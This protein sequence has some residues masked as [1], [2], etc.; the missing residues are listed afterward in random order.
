MMMRVIEP[1]SLSWGRQARDLIAAGVALPFGDGGA[2]AVARLIEVDESS[3]LVAAGDLPADW[4][5]E[6]ARLA[7]G[8]P[9]AGLP[10]EPLVMGILNVTPDSFSDGGSDRGVA[11]SVARAEAMAA[12]GA[13]IIDVGGES[14]RPRAAFVAEQEE[15]DRVV[16]VIEGLRGIAAKISI[17]TRRAAVMRAALAAGAD[18]INDVSGLSF[19]PAAGR[20]A[21]ETGAP[22]VLMHMRGDPMTMDRHTD[23]ADVAGEVTRE[24]TT[25]VAAALAAGVRR[26]AIMLDPGVGFAKTDA[27]SAELLNRL[28]MLANLGCPLL[29]GASR[30]RFIGKF[31]GV[32]AARDRQAGSVAAALAGIQR[33]ARIVRVHD[34]AAT[35]QAIRVWRALGRDT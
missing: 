14:T 8:R 31:S 27:Q 11:D 7:G 29:L 24:L 6:A 22:V 3:R 34:V 10:A 30:K 20:V 19:D 9:W 25:A 21:A 17:D 16:P 32:D 18:I 1:L 35:A 2:F 15:L 28:A 33:G 5:W 12:A 13:R 23:Y 26:E 4:R